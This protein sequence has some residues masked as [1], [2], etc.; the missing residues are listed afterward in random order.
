MPMPPT[1][2]AREPRRTIPRRRTTTRRR[3]GDFS[4]TTAGT[5]RRSSGT[6][7]SRWL[8][9]RLVSSCTSAARA[10]SRRRRGTRS[11]PSGFEPARSWSSASRA[12]R[13]R[14]RPRLC[15]RRVSPRRVSRRSPSKARVRTNLPAEET[16]R[17]DPR[18]RSEAATRLRPRRDP[19]RRGSRL[20]SAPP[21]EPR[22]KP[23]CVRCTK[24]R[25]VSRRAITTR[26]SASP[27]RPAWNSLKRSPRRSRRRRARRLISTTSPSSSPSPTRSRARRNLGPSGTTRSPMIV[28]SRIATT[29][30][31]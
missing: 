19:R 27:R 5:P 24:R 18:T 1:L 13:R 31:K 16:R 6:R 25:R 30:E 17:E 7:P 3:V 12:R 4:C 29:R 14:P 28:I 23:C 2:R 9:Q 15:A 26:R 21:P 10:C 22:T 20:R 11:S 8:F